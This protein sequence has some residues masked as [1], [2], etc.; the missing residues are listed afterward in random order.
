[1]ELKLKVTR[2]DTTYHVV[3]KPKAI[4]QYEEKHG[5]SIIE[6]ARGTFHVSDIWKLAF[7]ASKVAGIVPFSVKYQDW[8]DGLI[9]VEEMEEDTP[10]PT[11]AAPTATE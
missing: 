11:T 9:E 6:F 7:E 10:D 4:N 5:K 3:A 8:L 1:M 2:T